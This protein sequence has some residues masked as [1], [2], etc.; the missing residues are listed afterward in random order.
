MTLD[1][2]F[3]FCSYLGTLYPQYV[4]KKISSFQKM[5]KIVNYHNIARKSG[6]KN[7]QLKLR[8]YEKVTKFE[9]ISNLF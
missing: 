3:A 8:H 4:K 1:F 9:K 2:Y 6:A 5:E 7:I